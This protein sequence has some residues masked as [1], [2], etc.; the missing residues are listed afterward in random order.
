MDVLRKCAPPISTVI[1][2]L[3]AAGKRAGTCPQFARNFQLLSFGS[4]FLEA[5]E[6][7]LEQCVQREVM[8]E[9]GLHEGYSLL[10]SATALRPIPSGADGRLHC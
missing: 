4:G 9:T 5:G 2:V 8:E 6:K 7:L 3:T 1:I 10:T